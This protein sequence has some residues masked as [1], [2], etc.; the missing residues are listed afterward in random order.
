MYQTYHGITIIYCPKVFWMYLE[1]PYHALAYKKHD[2]KV[3]PCSKN[4]V[5]IP[6]IFSVPYLQY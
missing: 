4:I 2:I 3:D 5:I 6:S 1:V